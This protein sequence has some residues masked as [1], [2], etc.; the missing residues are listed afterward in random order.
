M[1]VNEQDEMIRHRDKLAS[2]QESQNARHRGAE[3]VQSNYT[4]NETPFNGEKSKEM[5]E[6]ELSEASPVRKSQ[7]SYG[8]GQFSVGASGGHKP[9]QYPHG[10]GLSQSR[11][12]AAQHSTHQSA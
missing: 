2:I 7:Y 5:I 3:M 10:S 6:F 8:T 1:S 12:K 11:K 9:G 4:Y